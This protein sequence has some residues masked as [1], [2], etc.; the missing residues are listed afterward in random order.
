MSEPM[1]PTPQQPEPGQNPPPPPQQ[2]V[3]PIAYHTPSDTE[4]EMVP[5]ART[6]GMLCH[7]LSLTAYISGVGL[8]VGPL[9]VWLVKKDQYEFV[10]D[11]GKESMNF[12]ITT[13]ITALL[14]IATACIGIGFIIL[15]LLGVVHLIFTIIAT[16]SAYSGNRY[17][18]PF[19]IRLIK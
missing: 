10:N 5:E 7:L 19:C 8:F 4:I 3:P 13:L 9:V 18:Y 1:D 2:P 6:M 17:R 12:Q 14:G 16:M 11:Q 15:M